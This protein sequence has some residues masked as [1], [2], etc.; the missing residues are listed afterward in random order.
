MSLSDLPTHECTYLKWCSLRRSGGNDNAVLH[1]IVLLERLDE[2]CDGGPLLAN[3]HVDTVEL[4]LLV[5]TLVPSVLVQHGVESDGC[6]SS[7]TIADNQFTLST[8]NRYHGVDRF[9]T[10]LH[11]L[12]DGAAGKDTGCLHL[13]TALLGGLDWAFAVDWVAESVD[14]TTE[15]LLS[16]WDI[17]LAYP[18]KTTYVHVN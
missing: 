5:V 15:E 12:V 13:G 3:S 11:W 14:D 10:G 2:L 16:D 8:A 17:D 4:H 7:L 6:L 1:G 9:E 18:L